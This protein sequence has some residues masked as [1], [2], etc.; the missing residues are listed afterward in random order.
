MKRILTLS[1]LMLLC[2]AITFT[3]AAQ[4]S[5]N[6]GAYM[7]SISTAQVEM[8]SKYMVYLSAAAHSNRKK[9]IEKLR[10]QAL[11]S[12]DKSRDKTLN[13]PQYK[14]DNTLRQSSSDYIRLV[15][16]VFNDDYAKIV[17]MEEIAEQSFDEMQ[18]FILLQQKTDEKL[19]EASKKMSNA[20]TA[21]ATKYNVKVV[22][23]K[24]ELEEKLSVSGKLNVYRNDIFLIFFKCNWQDGEIVKALNS[25]KLTLVEQGRTSLIRYADEGLAAI[26]NIKNFEGDYAL[27]DA[28]K[29][30]LQFYK[31]MATYDL[32]KLT[33]YLLKQESFNQMKKSFEK[34]STRSKDEIDSYNAAVKDINSMLEVYNSTNSRINSERNAMLNDWNKIQSDFADQHMPHYK[35]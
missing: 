29:M 11:E 16:N 14:G 27:K 25:G 35:K 28:C 7:T 34:K 15:Y 18:A 33:D 12:I 23:A 32:P 17:N 1:F 5:D 20:F 19:E 2:T 13:L 10:Q 22:D 8:N 6:P 30:S 9:K 3:S 4:D 31:R 26:V 21:F 24:D